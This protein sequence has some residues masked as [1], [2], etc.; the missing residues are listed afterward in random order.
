MNKC[1]E[2]SGE[3]AKAFQAWY[4]NQ[5]ESQES[6]AKRLGLNQSQ[7]SRLL[8]GQFSRITPP[9]RILCKYANIT[10]IK[11]PIDPKSNTRLMNAL[12]KTWDGT[13]RHANYIAK[14]I[15]ALKK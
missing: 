11:K 6:I 14:V 1:I 10:L 13:E 15:S 2:D 12:A 7:V 3:I 5:P 9:I 4:A 8:L